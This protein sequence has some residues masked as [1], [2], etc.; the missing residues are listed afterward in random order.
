MKSN[1][2]RPKTAARLLTCLLCLAPTAPTA[3][4][5]GNVAARQD[6]AQSQPAAGW[7]LVSPRGESF[8]VRMPVAPRVFVTKEE[9]RD[10]SDYSIGGQKIKRERTYHA[11][12]DGA[13][14]LVRLYKVSNP[15]K[16]LEGIVKGRWFRMSFVRDFRAG[17]VA[18]KEFESRSEAHYSRAHFFMADGYLFWAEAGARDAGHPAVERFLSSFRVGPPNPAGGPETTPASAAPPQETS[19]DDAAAFS[20]RDV[21]RKAIIFF[22]PEPLYTE[23]ARRSKTAGTVRLRFVLSSSGEVTGIQVVE[24]LRDG[25]TEKAIEAA[26]NIRFL[27]AEKDGGRV[28]QYVNVEYNFNIY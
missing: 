5:A 12:H 11:Y 18:A 2:P 16:L 15:E 26:R 24:G 20:T 25:L 10:Y 7:L 3:A 1:D 13:V 27:P 22:K 8:N 28:S 17:E 23:A 19:P 14:F 6:A 9:G 21:A 4:G